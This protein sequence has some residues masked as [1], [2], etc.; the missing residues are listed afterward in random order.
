M[1][2]LEL[3]AQ[4]STYKSNLIT[5]SCQNH[6]ITEK[7]RSGKKTCNLCSTGVKSGRMVRTFCS[8]CGVTLC[9]KLQAGFTTSCFNAW[10]TVDD[11]VGE[12]KRR[13]EA[14]TQSRLTKR[15]RQLPPL[16]DVDMNEEERERG[17]TAV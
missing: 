4:G 16:D 1:S 12:S 9:T 14:V 3:V 2:P 11:L 8:R 13:S 15:T 7:C 10:H 5:H 17:A 6:A